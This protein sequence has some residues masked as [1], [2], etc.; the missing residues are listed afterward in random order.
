MNTIRKSLISSYMGLFDL[1]LFFFPA[2]ALVL[3][4]ESI[5]AVEVVSP[6]QQVRI[7]FELKEGRPTYSIMYRGEMLVHASQLDLQAPG[8]E[9]PRPQWTVVDEGKSKDG[10]FS[11]SPIV[12]KQSV[13]KSENRQRTIRLNSDSGAWQM[14][15]IDLWADNRGAAIRYRIP[16]PKQPR[17]LKLRES[18]EMRLAGDPAMWSYRKERR[19]TG[20]V[21]LSEASGRL[22]PPVLLKFADDRW[23]A[24]HEADLHDSPWL[25][26]R[27]GDGKLSVKNVDYT[28]EGEWRSPW[29]AIMV[30]PSIAELVDS[31][32]LATLNPKADADEFAWVKPGVALWDWRSWGYSAPDG[33][34]YGLNLE[35]WKRFIDFAAEHQV[36]YV[37]LD[38]NWYG[39]EMQAS[40]DPFEGHLAADVRK[41][42]DYGKEKNVGLILY[43]ND[44]AGRKYGIEKILGEWSSWGAAGI[45]YGFMN[46][47]TAHEKVLWTRRIVRS[48]AENHLLVNFHDGPV[49]PAGDEAT[50]PNWST[51]EFCHAQ[52]DAKRA[53]S[54]TTF[55]LQMGVNQLAGPIDMNN[56]MFD[57]NKSVADR[58]R[59]FVEVPATITAEAARTL[60]VYSG[61]T[62]IPDAP[63][64]YARHPEL[65]QFVTAQQMPWSKS[66]T[67]DFELGETIT[68]MRQTG[69]KFLV[70]SATNEQPRKLKISLD[71]L[72]AD[73]K[74][75]A[76]ICSDASD[77]HYQTNREAYTTRTM[78][79]DST[80][81]IDA[82][83]A[84]GGGH[85][86]LIT[87]QD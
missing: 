50:L 15:E 30:A 47:Q 68:V 2:I 56:G 3:I 27:A 70:A 4:S 87:P 61:L 39:P 72:P 84:P 73:K 65:F 53:F 45:K 29:R 25:T 24:V 75:A 78:E 82:V 31:N 44:V 1:K 60:I 51:R 12:G 33:Y 28:V 32:L 36:P 23:A 69:E 59:V 26:W 80:T 49:P 7:D 43:L 52:S 42:I 21:K 6:D 40:S 71:F 85:C 55:L 20:P 77:A 74:F 38:A 9:Q 10:S 63:D 67:L 11:W 64:V 5:I 13:V 41:A 8:S 83:L 37:L 17:K 58:P 48:C 46:A 14:L 18:T 76:A 81:K 35:S 66:R 22:D 34:K 86:V 62:V 79:V 16:Q 19:P 54:P 57:L